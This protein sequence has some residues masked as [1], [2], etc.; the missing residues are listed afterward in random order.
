MDTY[1]PLVP[2]E[3]T[4]VQKYNALACLMFLKKKRYGHNKGRGHADGRK[5]PAYIG[6]EDTSYLTISTEELFLSYAIYVN[7]GGDMATVDRSG[8]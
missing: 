7:E 6:K 8:A 4:Q 3:M 2:E 1:E 5:Q